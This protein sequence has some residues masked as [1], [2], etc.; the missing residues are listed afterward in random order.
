MV[1]VICLRHLYRLND[2]PDSYLNVLPNYVV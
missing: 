2:L 1:P